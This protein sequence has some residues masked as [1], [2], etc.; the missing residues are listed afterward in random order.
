MQP[1]NK[2]NKKTVAALKDIQLRDASASNSDDSDDSDDLEDDDEDAQD[3]DDSDD[4]DDD[5]NAGRD[6]E[7]N[8]TQY[9]YTLFHVIFLLATCWVATL[10]TMNFDPTEE[11]DGFVAVGRTYWA[12]W[13]KIVSAWICYCM[14]I[15][16]LV[17]PIMMPD[18]F[19][20]A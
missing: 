11:N 20:F 9:N 18:R 7:R 4:E 16:T 13:V 12:S 17:A 2:P 1:F 14:Y 5:G 3:D 10:L 19:E 6:D 15:W 8:S